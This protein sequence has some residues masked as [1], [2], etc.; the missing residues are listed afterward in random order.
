MNITK[1]R[2]SLSVEEVFDYLYLKDQ[3]VWIEAVDLIAEYA[4]ESFQE[5]YEDEPDLDSPTSNGIN[6]SNDE[7]AIYF[8]F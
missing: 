5:H 4:E 8:E 7:E 2:I 6:Y 3:R 1:N